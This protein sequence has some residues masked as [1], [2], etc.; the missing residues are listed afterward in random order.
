M[1]WNF[2]VILLL[3]AKQAA[4]QCEAVLPFKESSVT[5]IQDVYQFKFL[6]KNPQNKL[7][8]LVYQLMHPGIVIDSNYYDWNNLSPQIRPVVD[9]IKMLEI[10][11]DI[12]AMR[13]KEAFLLLNLSYMIPF[14]MQDDMNLFTNLCYTLTEYGSAK[15]LNRYFLNNAVST[16]LGQIEFKQAVILKSKPMRLKMFKGITYCKPLQGDARVLYEMSREDPKPYD[17]AVEAIFAKYM[18]KH[19][20]MKSYFPIDSITLEVYQLP[21]FVD[22]IWDNCVPKVESSNGVNQLRL[23]VIFNV[24]K[25]SVTEPTYIQRVY[26]INNSLA[27]GQILVDKVFDPNFVS[28]TRKQCEGYDD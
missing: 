12:G 4:A 11:N 1:K 21:F 5:D 28:R 20:S 27:K 24:H 16:K 14:K 9:R 22:A 19:T 7:D 15:A 13:S 10:V 23:G 25:E 2:I 18:N 17:D 3:A 6:S 8:T 26:I